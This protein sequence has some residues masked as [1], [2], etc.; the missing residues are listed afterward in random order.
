MVATQIGNDARISLLYG[1]ADDAIF[2]F[3]AIEN[4]WAQYAGEKLATRKLAMVRLL[5]VN[6]VA[7]PANPYTNAAARPLLGGAGAP[8]EIGAYGTTT[9]GRQRPTSFTLFAASRL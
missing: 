2:G 4:E 1:D 9:S 6:L 7:F 5:A 3:I 8:V